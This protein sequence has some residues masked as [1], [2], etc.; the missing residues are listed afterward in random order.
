MGKSCKHFEDKYYEKQN[1]LHFVKVEKKQKIELDTFIDIPYFISTKRENELEECWKLSEEMKL[2]IVNCLNEII[3]CNINTV[4][5]KK[6]TI[7]WVLT[8]LPKLFGF[9]CEKQQINL[10]LFIVLNFNNEYYAKISSGK[11]TDWIDLKSTKLMNVINLNKAPLSHWWIKG[12]NICSQLTECV[13]CYED[14]SDNIKTKCKHIFCRQCIG[15]HVATNKQDC[16][17]C[18]TSLIC[19]RRGNQYDIINNSV[20]PQIN[21]SYYYDYAG[22]YFSNIPRMHNAH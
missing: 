12:F 17:Y 20:I 10:V 6:N 7:E 8:N 15:T 21:S 16:P 1:K 5:N 4:N 18:R 3:N 2:E 22:F 9:L 14:T 13:V 19:D 11:I